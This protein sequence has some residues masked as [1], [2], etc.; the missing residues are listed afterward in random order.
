LRER[1][2]ERYPGVPE[3]ANEILNPEIDYLTGVNRTPPR[4]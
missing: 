2:A 1:W 4:M 3:I